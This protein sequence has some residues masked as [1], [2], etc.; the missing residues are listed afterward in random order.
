MKTVNF[1]TPLRCLKIECGNL[2]SLYENNVFLGLLINAPSTTMSI[3]K[4][5][6]QNY[7]ACLHTY[8]TLLLPLTVNQEKTRKRKITPPHTHTNKHSWNFCCNMVAKSNCQWQTS[9]ENEYWFHLFTHLCLHHHGH[10][11]VLD[12]YPAFSQLD[13][14]SDHG[15][16][17]CGD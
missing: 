9:L 15:W 8:Q 17:S 14:C 13:V 12:I 10:A 11:Y 7:W 4:A 5:D 3:S 1:V 6:W 2:P 16:I